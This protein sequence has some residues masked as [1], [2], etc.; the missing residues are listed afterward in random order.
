MIDPNLLDEAITNV[1]K[2]EMMKKL[3]DHLILSAPPEFSAIFKEYNFLEEQQF[4]AS[5]VTE[6][7]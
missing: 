5:N 4:K 3:H 6:K 1:A 7:E 2:R